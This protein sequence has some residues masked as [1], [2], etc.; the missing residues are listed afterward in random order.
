MDYLHVFF[1]DGYEFDEE[2]KGKMGKNLRKH[3]DS[4]QTQQA[5]GNTLS[6]SEYAMNDKDWCYKYA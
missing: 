6:V 5:K 2:T 1:H 4:Y 3:A